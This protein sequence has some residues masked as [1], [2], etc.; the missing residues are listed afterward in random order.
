MLAEGRV[1][2]GKS[3][4]EEAETLK[5]LVETMN[6]KLVDETGLLKAKEKLRKVV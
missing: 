1:M 2:E 4:R 6:Y 3:P 5:A